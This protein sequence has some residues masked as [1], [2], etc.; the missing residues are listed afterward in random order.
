MNKHT[1]HFSNSLGFSVVGSLLIIALLGYLNFSTG[2]GFP[3]F[4]YPAFAVACWPLSIVFSHYHSMK[5]FS[6]V[7]SLAVIALLTVTNYLTSWDYPWFLYPSLA[8]IWWPIAMFY[9]KNR[10]KALSIAGILFI[11]CFSLLT[12]LLTTPSQLWFYYPVFAGIWWPLSIFLA[13]PRTAKIYSVSGAIIILAF[14]AADNAIHVPSCPWVLFTVYPVLLWPVCVFLGKKAQKLPIVSILSLAG[15]AYYCALNIWIF[16]GFPWAVFP[17]YLLLWGPLSVALGGRRCS[18][19]FS[20]CGSALSAALFITL[21]L[22]TTP[23]HIW[24]VYPIFALVWWPL[25]SYYFVYKPQKL[26]QR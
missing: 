11:F 5:A 18:L 24:A 23:H 15:I 10:S 9:G 20:L 25:S 13:R 21:N 3:W 1:N 4:I 14:L 8:V 2:G 16:P 17:A 19:P 22:I 12:N 6:L 26:Q 7:G